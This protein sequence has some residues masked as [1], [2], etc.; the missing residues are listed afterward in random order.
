MVASFQG[1]ALYWSPSTGAHAVKGA[2]LG[3]WASLGWER[4]WLGY[5]T[6][7]EYDVPGGRRSDFQGGWIDWTPGGGA[8]VRARR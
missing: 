2:I 7:D 8:V 3:A 6:S 4:S 1:G 5:P